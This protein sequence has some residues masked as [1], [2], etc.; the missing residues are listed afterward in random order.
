[1]NLK[2]LPTL[3]CSFLLIFSCVTSFGQEK[4]E[5]SKVVLI[6]IDGAADWILDD[7][8]DRNL[9]QKNGAFSTI[10]KK[11]TYAE[12]MIPVSI[13]ATAVSHISLF[14]GVQPNV[15]GIVGN[16]IL[17]PGEEIKSPRG[18][19]GFL[20]PIETETLWSAVM[21]QGKNVTNINAVGQDNSSSDR[22]GTRTFG[23]GKKLAN[24]VVKSMFL[25]EIIMTNGSS[26]FERIG[27][28]SSQTTAAFKLFKGGDVPVFCFIADSTFDDIINYDTVIVDFDENLENGHAGKLKANEWSEISFDVN[29]QKV[30]SWSY[31]MDLNSVTAESKVY[32]GAIGFNPSSPD[33]F[34]E[35]MENEV[36]MWPCEQDNMKLNKGLM[37]EQMWFDQAERLVKYYQNLLL[38]NINENNWDLL[39][40]YFTLIDD[41]QHRFLLKDS[42]QLDYNMEKGERRKRYDNYVVWA[43]QTIDNLL[44]ELM[45]AAPKS[46]NFI[47]VSDH[48]VAPIHSVVLINRL[49][50]ENGISITG[51]SIEARAYSSGPAAHIYVNV[52]GRQEN[53]T[54]PKSEL[55]KYIAKISKACK[56]LKDPLTGSPIFSVVL[57]TSELENL[58]LNHSNRSGDIFVSARIGWSLSSKLVSGIPVTIP[59]SFNKDAYAHLNENIQRFLSSGFMNETGLGVHGNLGGDRNMHAIFY[60]FGPKVSQKN[61][62][63]ISALDVTPTVSS[64][65][66]IKP[67]SKAKGAV[68][69][70]N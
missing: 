68:V 24:S 61:I 12:S 35:K 13:S 4:T 57:E 19:S 7:L 8:L 60:A 29:G 10:R 41:V 69:I 49:L 45:Q 5:D 21:R 34:K 1:M 65:L 70:K 54:V 23:Y 37:T 18:T 67:P 42:R 17:L 50:E 46:V 31:L 30:L 11:G 3:T 33:T 28:L 9:L 63:V 27:K 64:L 48:G 25:G 40:G 62:G 20:A 59:N 2:I 56:E 32:F 51:D 43:Y 66:K 26:K 38:A 52:K 6:S 15:H 55:P 44:N 16:N 58:Q 22:M 36:G 47:I 53:G 14:T 39:S